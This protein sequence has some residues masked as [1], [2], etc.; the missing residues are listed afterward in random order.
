MRYQN[1]GIKDTRKA[2]KTICWLFDFT[3][4]DEIVSNNYNDRGVIQDD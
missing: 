4:G 2:D 1:R 3:R